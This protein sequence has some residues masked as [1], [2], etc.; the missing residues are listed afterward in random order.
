MKDVISIRRD[1]HKYPEEGFLEFRTA[2]KV[3]QHL[4]KYGYEV[5]VGEEVMD[6]NSLRG[7][8]S[9]SKINQHYNMVLEE[10]ESSHLIKKMKGGMTGVVG[11]LDG[12]NPGPTIAIRFDMDAL[13]IR[14]SNNSTHLPRR[15]NFHSVRE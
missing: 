11:I 8:P 5:L 2:L 9:K 13:P 14:E 7:L 3:I 6:K 12:E 15:E 1:F 10:S 4:K